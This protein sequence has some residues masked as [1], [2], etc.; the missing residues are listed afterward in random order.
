M[1]TVENLREQKKAETRTRVL[2]VAHRRF[3]QKG[4]DATTI[5]EICAEA[6]I[7]KRTFF[8]YFHDK[9]TLVTPNRE[10][11]LEHFREVLASSPPTE[12][13]FDI[14][15]RATR[16]L[17]SEYTENREQLLQ[18]QHLVDSSTALL[19]RQREIDRDWEREIARTFVSRLPPGRESEQRAQVLAGAMIG[20]VRATLR[21][22]FEA[23]CR[24]DLDALG[25]EALD[26]LESGFR[27]EPDVPSRR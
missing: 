9:E 4:Y 22:W 27:I 7:S 14:F 23:G 5:E 20:V 2:D 11:R 1:P 6:R 26:C 16:I 12:S 25:Q 3:G 18:R 13:P 10:I 19:A 8:R 21:T 24:P 15:R 17:A